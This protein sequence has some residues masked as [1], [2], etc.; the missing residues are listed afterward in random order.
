MKEQEKLLRS[1]LIQN[2]SISWC[3]DQL[4]F[5]IGEMKRIENYN[6]TD[7]NDKVYYNELQGRYNYLLKKSFFENKE[8]SKFKNKLEKV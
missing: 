1:I 6:D 8:M 7:L 5:V 4:V 2:A 3:R